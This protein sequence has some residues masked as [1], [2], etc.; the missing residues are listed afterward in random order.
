[1]RMAIVK[2][3]DDEAIV[4]SIDAGVSSY[5]VNGLA[6]YIVILAPA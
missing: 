1:M 3:S 4:A 2:E 6:A 5:V